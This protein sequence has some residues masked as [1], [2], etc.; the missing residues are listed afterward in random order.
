MSKGIV[1]YTD[2]RLEERIFSTCQ[3]HILAADLP[4]VSVSLQP[5]N[6]GQNIVVKG[7]PGY[8]S[9]VNQIVTALE[10]TTADYVFFCEHDILYHKSHFRTK[11]GSL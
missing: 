1:Y 4:I 5:I 10:A 6:F 11:T 7:E 2:N 8:P 3:K 9:M